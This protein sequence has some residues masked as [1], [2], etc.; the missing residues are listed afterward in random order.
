MIKPVPPDQL[1]K[2]KAE[3]AA[4]AKGVC[5]G[6]NEYGF[7]TAA[8]VCPK[9]DPKDRVTTDIEDEDAVVNMVGDW[10]IEHARFTGKQRGDVLVIKQLTEIRGCPTC[11][12]PVSE[13]TII[14]LVLEFQPQTMFELPVEGD[15]P[16]LVVTA[17]ANGVTKVEGFL[18]PRPALPLEA[19]IAS[20]K[21][22]TS[23][24]GTPLL[25]SNAKEDAGGDSSEHLID[26][27]DVRH[28]AKRVVF[29]KRS[30]KGLEIRLAWK[31]P[32]G[33]ETVWTAY[34]DAI[35]GETLRMVAPVKP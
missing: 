21:A 2:L 27:Q 16:T 15:V 3:F 25:A 24:L 20:D 6:L 9:P 19:T 17:N 33:Q 31:I 34:V 29:V 5:A 23:L 14:G 10:M 18:V 11:T 4:S 35:T 8:P 30:S 28:P 12:P 26:L 1:A 22:S 13:D 32:V 7:T